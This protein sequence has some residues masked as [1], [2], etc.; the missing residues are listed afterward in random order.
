MTTLVADPSLFAAFAIAVVDD[1]DLVP[2]THVRLLPSPALGLPIG[3]FLLWGI[4]QPEITD[5]NAFWTDSTGHRTQV[6]QDSW[7]GDLNGAVMPVPPDIHLAGVQVLPKQIDHPFA[8]SL[9]DKGSGRIISARS[10]PLYSLA[11]PLISKL[12]LNGQ[13]PVTAIKAYSLFDTAIIERIL[14]FAPDQTLSLRLTTCHGT[15]A[16]SA[17]IMRS[18]SCA[19]LLPAA[20]DLPTVPMDLSIHFLPERN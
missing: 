20:L 9:L 19:S 11:A 8:A 15:E 17:E 3:P 2:G 4:D 18:A 6:D 1:P 5:L 7:M 14:N 13:G 12:R 16:R 10:T